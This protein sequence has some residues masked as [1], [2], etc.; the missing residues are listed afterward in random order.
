MKENSTDNNLE[1]KTIEKKRNEYLIKA[2]TNNNSSLNILVKKENDFYWYES[3][4]TEDYIQ[5]VFDSKININDICNLIEQG[6]FDIEKNK[7]YLKLIFFYNQSKRKLNIEISLLELFN[8]LNNKRKTK[9]LLIIII[10]IMMI[11]IFS[12]NIFLF[13]LFN[14]N[15]NKINKNENNKIVNDE[16]TDLNEKINEIENNKITNL[17]NKLDMIENNKIIIR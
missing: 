8:E 6:E 11:L 7:N 13:S 14:K 16:I 12:L 17:N 15:N 9:D 2:I 1:P 3:N 4:F 5:Q 10:I